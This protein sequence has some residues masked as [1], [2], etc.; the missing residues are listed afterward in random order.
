MG[1]FW[2]DTERGN[3]INYGTF[4][5]EL[6]AAGNNS[7]FIQEEDPFLVFKMLIRNLLNQKES[8]ILD[9]NFSDTELSELGVSDEDLKN[10]KYMQEDLSSR[11]KSLNEVRSH[12]KLLSDLLELTIYTSGTSGKP[13]KVTQSLNNVTRAVQVKKDHNEHNWGFAYNPTHFAGL[14][15]F[16]QAFYN[17]NTLVYLFQKAFEKVYQ[18]LR[19]ANITHLSCTPTFMKM[20]LPAI[21][22][23]L[24]L[25]EV[26]TFGGEPFDSRIDQKIRTFF[27]NSKIKNVYASTEAGSLL[28]GEG[29]YFLIPDRYKN[30]LKIKDGEL[31]IHNSLLGKSHTFILKDGWYHTGDLVQM[32]EDKKFKF[33]NRK[34]DSINVGGYKVNPKEIENVIKEIPG[35]VD[36]LV[37]GRKNSLLGNV[38]VAEVIP[39]NIQDISELKKLI[40]ST[41]KEQLQEFKK[42]HQIKFVNHF[43]FTRTGKIKRT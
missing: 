29:E 22:K 8:I 19:D 11:F 3:K 15:V 1:L 13:K 39:E 5:V 27:P 6:T 40:N 30:V 33:K 41:T 17:Q 10:G 7:I 12:L 23:P 35:V 26:L 32:E 25:I 42:P 4:L 43:E 20:L 2:L 31:I 36:V 28:R 14:Q 21:E 9:A 18:D 16:F 38:I 37:K 34:T 24:P